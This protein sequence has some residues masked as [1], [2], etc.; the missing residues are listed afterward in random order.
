MIVTTH[1]GRI[2][3]AIHRICHHGA[4]VVNARGGYMGQDKTIVYSIVAADDTTRIYALCKSID[5]GAFIN[6][7]STSRVIGRFY[8]RPRD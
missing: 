5:P 7:I 6:T 3:E 8:M 1:P 2:C 4:T